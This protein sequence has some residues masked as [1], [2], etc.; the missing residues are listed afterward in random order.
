MPFLFVEAIFQEKSRTCSILSGEKL[1][2]GTTL[3]GSKAI[4]TWRNGD[5]FL[6]DRSLWW[7]RTYQSLLQATRTDSIEI[8][9]MARN[10][11]AGLSRYQAGEFLQTKKARINHLAALGTN[12]VWVGIGFFP[13]IPVGQIA[14]LKFQYFPFAL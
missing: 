12:N 7:W 6:G 5:H 4:V 1:K 14:E 10:L 3:A 13:V 9:T 8:Q 11:K 2:P